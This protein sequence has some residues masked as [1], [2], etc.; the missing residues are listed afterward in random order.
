MWASEERSASRQ[1]H[2]QTGR[3]R[4]NDV[5]TDRK[6]YGPLRRGLLQHRNTPRPTDIGQMIQKQEGI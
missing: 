2:A 5:N 4:S 6:G 3:H 1:K